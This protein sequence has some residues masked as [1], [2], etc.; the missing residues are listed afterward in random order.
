MPPPRVG[1]RA[2]DRALG[3]VTALPPEHR[4]REDVVEDLPASRL[5][6]PQDA[7]AGKD[8]DDSAHLVIRAS[9]NC[10][11]SDVSWAIFVPDGVTRCSKS[12]AAM[13]RCAGVERLDRA[14]EVVGHDLR[15]RRRAR[16]A[17]RRGASS[18]QPRAR[19]PTAAASRAG[20]TAPRCPGARPFAPDARRGR[21]GRA[22]CA[23]RR[24]RR[25][26]ARPARPRSSTVLPL[27]LRPSAR[28]AAR[29][30][31]APRLGRA[32]RGAGRCR[33]GS[34]SRAFSRSSEASVSSRSES[35][36]LTRSGPVH[37]RGER[38]VEAVRRRRGR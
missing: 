27:E 18:S 7:V 25:A 32:G 6:R 20:G 3:V 2:R 16:R 22:R 15:R 14:L 4:A 37:E 36:T 13:S 17:S 23:R 8:A 33:T 1:A 21:R 29:S 24:R 9:A 34:G 28:A 11:R 26:R 12:R 30:P 35:S 38:A 31:P 19:R 10:A 5:V